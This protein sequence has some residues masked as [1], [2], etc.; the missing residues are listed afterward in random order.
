MRPQHRAPALHLLLQPSQIELFPPSLYIPEVLLQAVHALVY[1]AVLSQQLGRAVALA[2]L[3]LGHLPRQ[4]REDVLLFY[5]VVQGQLAHELQPLAY[6]GLER[7][8]R[9]APAGCARGPEEVPSRPE[10]CVVHLHVFG[11][12]VVRAELGRR[13]G[14]KLSLARLL[15]QACCGGGGV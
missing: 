15:R 11:H 2:G 4:H 14:R 13:Q 9:G 10:V 8:A 5:V 12:V 6:E 7:H 1:L 3:E